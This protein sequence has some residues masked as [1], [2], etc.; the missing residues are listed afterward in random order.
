MDLRLKARGK[1][2]E[3]LLATKFGCASGVKPVHCAPEY[4]PQ[5]LEASLQRLG[6]DYVDLYYTHRYARFGSHK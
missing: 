6:T 1:R 3:I 5:A 2:S 4:V